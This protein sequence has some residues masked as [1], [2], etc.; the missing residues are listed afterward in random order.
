MKLI[1][2][3][4]NPGKSYQQNR[5]N[6]GIIFVDWL[7]SKSKLSVAHQTSSYIQY[8][9]KSTDKIICNSLVYMNLSGRAIASIKKKN[10]SLLP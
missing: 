6:A 10:P 5:H 2:G 4:G 3:I 8:S 7:A 1:L 9:P